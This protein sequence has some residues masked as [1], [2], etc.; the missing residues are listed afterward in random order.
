MADALRE[1]VCV[2]A[3]DADARGDTEAEGE[4]L[5]EYEYEGDE[6]CDRA[7]MLVAGATVIAAVPDAVLEATDEREGTDDT[8]SVAEGAADA[9][10]AP[11]PVGN[12]EFDA[13]LVTV[14]VTVGIADAVGEHAG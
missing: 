13:D 10:V 8:D 4:A 14:G 6:L 3:G 1:S 2:G 11:L 5:V 9:D 7:L 12:A